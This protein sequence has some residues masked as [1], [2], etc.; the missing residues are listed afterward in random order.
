MCVCVVLCSV[1]GSTCI[2]VSCF[3]VHVR[4]CIAPARGGVARTRG[5]EE[6]VFFFFEMGVCG[7]RAKMCV[8]VRLSPWLKSYRVARE[9]MVV[10]F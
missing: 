10:R 2:F 3:Q 8:A 1:E 4:G 9:G 7:V 5:G 6:W